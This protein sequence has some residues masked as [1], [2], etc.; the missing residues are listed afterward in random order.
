MSWTGTP[1]PPP[2]DLR[3]RPRGLRGVDAFVCAAESQAGGSRYARPQQQRRVLVRVLLP[4]GSFGRSVALPVTVIEADPAH[5]RSRR[6][7]A[8]GVAVVLACLLAAATALLVR[9][10]SDDL[11][12]R[13]SYLHSTGKLVAARDGKKDLRLP[14]APGTTQYVTVSVRN[15]GSRAVRI[16]AI[17]YDRP[18]LAPLWVV[19]AR[20]GSVPRSAR[21]APGLRDFP[22]T[23]RAG[24]EVSVQ[25]AVQQRRCGWLGGSGAG[26]SLLPVRTNRLGQSHAWSV[27][28]VPSG[29]SVVA[30]AVVPPQLS[31]GCPE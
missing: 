16:D 18:V 15:G 19:G 25:L 30:P 28:E 9:A 21:A 10:R 26:Y 7:L 27:P 5:R 12:V 29:F 31:A 13:G 6:A 22:V 4:P 8:T 3:A 1:P 14:W 23:V 20:W 24:Q 11:L 17:P 2:W